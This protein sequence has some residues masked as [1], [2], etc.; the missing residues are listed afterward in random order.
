VTSTITDN[1]SHHPNSEMPK[2][3]MLGRECI[4]ILEDYCDRTP[5]KKQGFVSQDPTGGFSTKRECVNT[6]LS[7]QYHDIQFIKSYYILSAM[8]YDL[9]KMK[10]KRCFNIYIRVFAEAMSLTI[11]ILSSP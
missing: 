3:F 4:Y 1:L 7:I 5:L 11:S 9:Q 8:F 6:H 10:L 2:E